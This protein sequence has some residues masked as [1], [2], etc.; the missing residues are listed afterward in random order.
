MSERNRKKLG[1]QGEELAARYLQAKNYRILERNYRRARGEIDIVAQQDDTLVFVE[2]KTARSDS[3]GPPAAWVDAKKQ[4]QL[5]Q[6][7]L[8]YLQENEIENMDCRF[9]VVAIHARSGKWEI[10]HI[11]NAFWLTAP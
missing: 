2:V 8:H 5:G 9:D 7:A 11:E 4:A 1:Q 10:Q 6:V 3:F